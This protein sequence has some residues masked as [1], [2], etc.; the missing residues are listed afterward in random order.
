MTPRLFYAIMCDKEFVRHVSRE[1]SSSHTESIILDVA[2]CSA[3]FVNNFIDAIDLH[4]VCEQL[5]P[6]K[7]FYIQ[8]FNY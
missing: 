2:P 1:Q 8:P 7:K 4:T 5:Y 3:T 6:H